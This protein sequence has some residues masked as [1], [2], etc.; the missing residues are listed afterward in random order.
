MLK[1]LFILL[2]INVIGSLTADFRQVNTSELLVKP[3]VSTGR[4]AYRAPNYLRWEYVSPSPLVWEVNGQQS[5]ANKNVTRLVNVI[6]QTINGTNFQSNQQFDV[7][8]VDKNVYVMHPKIREMK[9]FFTSITVTLNAATHIAEKVEI[10]EVGGG[11]TTLTFSN[12]H[13][14][15]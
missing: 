15:K 1:C 7:N 12:V 6:L 11:N 4:L 14:D 10:E 9:R 5:N 2:Q 3:Q 8:N 13:A